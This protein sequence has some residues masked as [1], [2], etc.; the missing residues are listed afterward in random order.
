M[1]LVTFKDNGIVQLLIKRGLTLT[2]RH[3]TEHSLW[4]EDIYDS[5]G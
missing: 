1:F 3:K 5:C 4:S 2:M